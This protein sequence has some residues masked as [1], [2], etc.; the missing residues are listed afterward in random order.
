MQAEAALDEE[1]ARVFN[2]LNGETEEK[3]LKVGRDI[4][5]G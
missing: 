4:R 3:L 5:E 1:R 2:Y